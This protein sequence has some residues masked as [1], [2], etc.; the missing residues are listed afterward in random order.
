MIFNHGKLGKYTFQVLRPTPKAL[1]VYVRTVEVGSLAED[2]V[3]LLDCPVLWDSDCD[4]HIEAQMPL[5]AKSSSCLQN[6]EGK[7]LD[8]ERMTVERDV[9][10][11]QQT[12][13][14]KNHKISHLDQ[15]KVMLEAYHGSYFSMLILGNSV[16]QMCR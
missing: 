13:L 14:I 11:C 2:G 7:C 1:S 8:H 5:F 4:F 3:L 16:L 6:K 9:F 10:G 12:G 15:S